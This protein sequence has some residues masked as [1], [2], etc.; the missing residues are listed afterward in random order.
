MARYCRVG[1]MGG[2]LQAAW[3]DAA[4][5]RWRG[6]SKEEWAAGWEAW[7]ARAARGLLAE[8]DDTRE[9]RRGEGHDGEAALTEEGDIL[10]G[11]V[12]FDL[13]ECNRARESAADAE[14][15]G[16]PVALGGGGIREVLA[17]DLGGAD[18]FFGAHAGVKEH[19]ITGAHGA[20]KITGLEITHAVPDR[21][22]IDD[23]GRPRV[24]C[25]FGF[26]QPVLSCLGHGE[27]DVGRPLTGEGERRSKPGSRF[28]QR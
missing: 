26:H 17:A 24:G 27:G 19:G 6:M 15:D 13:G 14:L 12:G 8:G 10:E 22:T 25:G 7:G 20:E 2:G 21:A 5:R 23:E 3:N 1:F 4:L 11:G 28:C 18:D 16:G 9:F